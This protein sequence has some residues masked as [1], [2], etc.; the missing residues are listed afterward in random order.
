MS[1]RIIAKCPKCGNNWI[2]DS[3]VADKRIR[4]RK[5]G[6][7]FNVPKLEELPKAINVIKEAKGPVYVD[8]DGKTYG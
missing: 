2:L 4:C 1:M 3:S 5:C 7:L 6:S 8:R